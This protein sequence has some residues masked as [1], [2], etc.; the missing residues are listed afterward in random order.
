M[1]EEFGGS[2]GVALVA[3]KPGDKAN[4]GHQVKGLSA[5]SQKCVALVQHVGPMHQTHSGV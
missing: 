1:Q 2:S 5:A 3:L 4:M